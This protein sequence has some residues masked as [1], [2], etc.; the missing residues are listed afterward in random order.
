SGGIYADF[1]IKDYS[2][3]TTNLRLLYDGFGLPSLEILKGSSFDAIKMISW[4]DFR[5]SF[6]YR[7]DTVTTVYMEPPTGAIYDVGAMRP[8]SG[9]YLSVVQGRYA[10]AWQITDVTFLR[11][12]EKGMLARGGAY[13]LGRL[14]VEIAYIVADKILG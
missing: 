2:G 10:N 7:T 3:R 1:A 14:G 13:D 6:V 4:G 5:L 12:M 11:D 9:Q 8:Y